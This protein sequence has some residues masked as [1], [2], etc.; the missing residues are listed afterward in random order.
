MPSEA[1]RLAR[2][3]VEMRTAQQVFYRRKGKADLIRA[4]VLE[5]QVDEACKRTIARKEQGILWDQP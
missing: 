4:K 2:L 1:K 3:V 5:R